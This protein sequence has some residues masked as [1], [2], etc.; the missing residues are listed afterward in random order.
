MS[1]DR[2]PIACKTI[3]FDTIGAEPGT[4]AATTD[5]IVDAKLK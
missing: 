3:V 5:P 2:I 1:A 4:G